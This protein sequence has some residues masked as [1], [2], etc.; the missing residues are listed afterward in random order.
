MFIGFVNHDT[1]FV[2]V[3]PVTGLFEEPVTST[4]NYKVY[5]PLGDLMANSTGIATQVLAGIYKATLPV[6]TVNQYEAGKFYNLVV[7]YT[8][9]DGTKTST[10]MKFFTFGAV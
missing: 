10:K 5:G 2:A 4:T 8:V 1:D 9:T 3:F 6:K 7:T